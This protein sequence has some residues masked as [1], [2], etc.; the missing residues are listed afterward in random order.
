MEEIEVNIKKGTDRIIVSI[1]L[2][3]APLL[4]A[5]TLMNCEKITKDEVVVIWFVYS[6]FLGFLFYFF[7]LFI[8]FLFNWVYDGFYEK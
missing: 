8:K 6:I 7:L 4:C 2:L 1:S 5:F 3:F